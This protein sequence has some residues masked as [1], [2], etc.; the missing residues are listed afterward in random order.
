[1]PTKYLPKQ[2]IFEKICREGKQIPNSFF[3]KL[4]LKEKSR[5]RKVKNGIRD[6]VERDRANS[7]NDTTNGG[8]G[9]QYLANNGTLKPG[10]ILT[11]VGNQPPAVTPQDNRSDEETNQNSALPFLQMENG[12]YIV[13]NLTFKLSNNVPQRMSYQSYQKQSTY[14]RNLWI[15][16]ET[17]VSTIGKLSR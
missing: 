8:L 3:D 6:Q 9:F 2:E 11:P 13:Q 4:T 14:K 16:N 1:M 12:N 10:R 17:N 7:D 5:M 15:N